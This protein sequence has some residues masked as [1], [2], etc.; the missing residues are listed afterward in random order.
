MYGNVNGPA[1]DTLVQ[2]KQ[3][4]NP[5]IFES[6]LARNIEGI[7]IRRVIRCKTR[8][9]FACFCLHIGLVGLLG[10]YEGSAYNLCKSVVVCR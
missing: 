4:E 10:L 5:G 1:F 8:A 2:K 7:R 9:N 6:P 3:K